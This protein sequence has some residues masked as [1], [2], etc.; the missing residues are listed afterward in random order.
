[1]A[2]L[3]AHIKWMEI[4]QRTSIILLHQVHS[5]RAFTQLTF[6]KISLCISISSTEILV[7]L[8]FFGV[9]VFVK[10]RASPSERQRLHSEEN[11]S[12]KSQ[13]CDPS[14]NDNESLMR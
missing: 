3:E 7:K 4:L 12:M 10:P 13:F 8:C 9:S 5:P 2:A 6:Q 11:R 1:M 14:K